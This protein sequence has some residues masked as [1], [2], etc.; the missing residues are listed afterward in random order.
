M[1]RARFSPQFH[2]HLRMQR[3]LVAL[4]VLQRL[5]RSHGQS[6][7]VVVFNTS[8][9]SENV[10]LYKSLRDRH[11]KFQVRSLAERASRRGLS[12]RNHGSEAAI[13]DE[14]PAFDDQACEKLN[15]AESS[16][17]NCSA[18]SGLPVT[19]CLKRY[20]M[21]LR[22]V[23]TATRDGQAAINQPSCRLAGLGRGLC[24]SARSILGSGTRQ[25]VQREA[26]N[27]YAVWM[28]QLGSHETND[29]DCARFHLQHDLRWNPLVWL[30]AEAGKSGAWDTALV[31]WLRSAK[32]Y[33]SE[34]ADTAERTYYGPP[35]V[36]FV[37]A[38]GTALSARSLPAG[39]AG[40]RAYRLKQMHE[41]E[42]CRTLLLSTGSGIRDVKQ[43]IEFGG[44]AGHLEAAI[45]DL[46]FGGVHVV[47]DLPQMLL[48]QRYWLRHA[49]IPIYLTGV[50]LQPEWLTP[51]LA[52][53]RSFQVSSISQPPHLPLLLQRTG[54][55]LRDTVFWATWSFTEA[56]VKARET[57]RP[58]IKG[59]GR[60]FIAFWDDFK[61]VDNKG[62]LVRMVRQDFGATHSM[63]VWRKKTCDPGRPTYYLVLVDKSIG[64][65]SCSAEI[66]C[67][68]DTKH[69][70]FMKRAATGLNMPTC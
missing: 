47:Y 21:L 20:E 38:S 23:K 7:N 69:H 45:R 67:S 49:S 39:D 35:S 24:S 16:L 2:T 32:D 12:I 50:D 54:V 4:L 59:V 43:L 26:Q 14:K 53:G 51:Q 52:R 58:H 46:G 17:L 29:R 25:I 65:A 61:G 5:H 22:A 8:G 19:R 57:I 1:P 33:A 15:H 44:G 36:A 6:L 55:S 18:D 10:I 11:V 60:V 3:L 27:I 30:W 34:W 40:K 62:Y 66:G 41:V 42:Q 64:S 31:P 70:T 37:N 48:M 68:A 28:K 63:C 13:R 9:E 56:G